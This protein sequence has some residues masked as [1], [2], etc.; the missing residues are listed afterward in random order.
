MP[1]PKYIATPNALLNALLRDRALNRKHNFKMSVIPP[2]MRSSI[3]EVSPFTLRE[4]LF[5]ERSPSA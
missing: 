4:G 3:E 5:F 2:T 1:R